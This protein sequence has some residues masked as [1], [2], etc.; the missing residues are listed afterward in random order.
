MIAPLVVSCVAIFTSLA[1]QDDA[2]QRGAR[3]LTAPLQEDDFSY[4]Q[5]HA[6]VIGINNYA[7]E[8]LQD[9]QH[10]GLDAAGFAETLIRELGFP[11][12][13]VRLLRDEG[14]TKAAIEAALQDWL[15]DGQRIEAEDLVVVFFAGHG[16]TRDIGEKTNRGY[17]VPC[18]GRYNDQGQAL[19]SSFVS[20][21][22]LEEISDMIPAKHVLF[23]L[24]CCFGGLAVERG[25]VLAGGLNIPA[26]MVITAGTAEQTVLDGGG[27]GH[28]IFTAALLEA[29]HGES[30]AA[31]DNGDGLVD[32]GELY[33]HVS[34]RVTSQSLNRQTPGLGTFP[35]HKGGMV[36]LFPPNVKATGLTS[37]ERLQRLEQTAEDYRQET[38]QLAD[39][40]LLDDLLQEAERLWPRRPDTVPVMRAWLSRAGDLLSREPLHLEVLGRVIEKALLEEI[41][42]GRTVEGERI[43][44]EWSRAEPELRWR[45]S[46]FK[47]VVDKLAILRTTITDIEDRLRFAEIIE[48]RTV[49][50][51]EEAWTDAIAAIAEEPPY[52]GLELEP[53]V[54]L[55]PLEP[56]PDSGLWEFWYYESGTRPVRDAATGRWE[57]TGETG[58]VLVLLPGGSFRLGARAPR[59]DESGPNID[60]FCDSPEGPVHEVTLA[61]FFVSKYEMTQGQW[62]RFTGVNPSYYGPRSAFG[63]KIHDLSHPVEQVSWHAAYAT[64]GQM[65]LELPT[66]VQWEYAT[67]AGT[68]SV[69]WTGDAKDSIAG[70]ANLAD[71]FARENRGES[72]WH[73]ELEFDDGYTMH[74]PVGS[75]RPNAFGLHDTMGNLWE[76]CLDWYGGYH[77]PV[78]EGSGERLIPE[79]FRNAKIFRGGGFIGDAE[80]LRS[81]YREHAAPD[82]TAVYNGVRP[83][84]NLTR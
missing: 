27:G 24:D 19:W 57:I 60:P 35:G 80:S 71:R 83:V 6:L 36:A 46:A 30:P 39:A 17:L 66:E 61:P 4:R 7:D 73:Y 9:L 44:P 45:H 70:T 29:V 1:P 2:A 75:F 54:G 48:T 20:I 22:A 13:R 67:R 41:V 25:T 62:Q 64:L 32:F 69:W 12:E 50:D 3:P 34:Q 15:C 38:R 78:Q 26:R 56:D 40:I 68:T 31:D 23:V 11:P 72:H 14:A 82:S 47:D 8:A 55:V 5:R 84:M 52:D 58:I 18:D 79:P 33:R 77:Y 49:V 65:G 76:W 10:A 59:K 28:S 37:A 74:A 21:E 63:N 81:A 16:L 43:E 42:A 53:I 51:H